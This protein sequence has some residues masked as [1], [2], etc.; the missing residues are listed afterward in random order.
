[1]PKWLNKRIV[2][3]IKTSALPACM[4]VGLNT[5]MFSVSFFKN[6]LNVQEKRRSWEIWTGK[7]THDCTKNVT[8]TLCKQESIP[9]GC[10][11]P[12]LLTRGGGG[13]GAVGGGVLSG[14]V[15]LSITGSDIISPPLWTEWLIDRCKNITLPQASFAGGNKMKVIGVD[16]KDFFLP[17]LF[18]FNTIFCLTAPATLNLL[19]LKICTCFFPSSPNPWETLEAHLQLLRELC[20]GRILISANE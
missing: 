9:V 14:G 12:R 10:L 7:N 1:M 8:V 11:P 13:G 4:Q 2:N 6:N 15:M 16:S 20:R 19:N 18:L 17:P 3:T 5:N